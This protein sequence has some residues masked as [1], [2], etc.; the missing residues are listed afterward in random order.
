MPHS[1]LFMSLFMHLPFSLFSWPYE[2]R[3]GDLRTCRRIRTS[4][5]QF[6]VSWYA[7]GGR[8]IVTSETCF[9]YHDRPQTLLIQTASGWTNLRE[10]RL[11]GIE[12]GGARP[13]HPSC[14]S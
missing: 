7:Q 14:S 10:L 11:A 2:C 3:N 1:S 9:G 12:G 4:Y 13:K 5:L 6:A 8:V